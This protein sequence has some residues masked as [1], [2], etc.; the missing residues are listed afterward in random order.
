MSLKLYSTVNQKSSLTRYRIQCTSE[1]KTDRYTVCE[2][3]CCDHVF[4]RRNVF[5]ATSRTRRRRRDTRIRPRQQNERTEGGRPTH[6]WWWM[7]KLTWL[8]TERQGFAKS[9]WRRRENASSVGI[10]R[11]VAFVDT[12]GAAKHRETLVAVSTPLFTLYASLARRATP[13]ATIGAARFFVKRI[14]SISILVCGSNANTSPSI[15]C[16]WQVL[17]ST[18]LPMLNQSL[19]P[20]IF[21]CRRTGGRAVHL[22]RSSRHLASDRRL[23]L[24][25]PVLK[26]F[27]V[28]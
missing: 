26:N 18:V 9:G 23:N 16:S 22:S 28:H 27:I 4:S 17:Q 5:R 21:D 20:A 2:D 12:P 19:A 8:A 15:S 11:N 1:K 13:R 25:S 3:G 14:L 24:E 6:G 10:A 7:T